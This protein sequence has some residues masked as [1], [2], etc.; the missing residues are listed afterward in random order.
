MIFQSGVVAAAGGDFGDSRGPPCEMVLP[1]R[2]EALAGL[3]VISVV[4]GGHH[5]GKKSS[6]VVPMVVTHRVGWRPLLATHHAHNEHEH[7][8]S[9]INYIY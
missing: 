4:C 9:V 7:V 6:Y 8:F 3:F 2:V 5:T 1:C